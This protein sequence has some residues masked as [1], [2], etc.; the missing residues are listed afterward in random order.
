MNLSKEERQH[1]SELFKMYYRRDRKKLIE[2][3]AKWREENPDKVQ[4]H[5]EH[6]LEVRDPDH[7]NKILKERADLKALAAKAGCTVPLTIT[8]EQ[9]KKCT[10]F[11]E[12]LIEKRDK[13]K[14][15]G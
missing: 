7:L 2:G 13:L 1:R 12:K 4:K 9:N 11:F 14:K 8:R 10:E 6:M 15:S 5:V 3:L